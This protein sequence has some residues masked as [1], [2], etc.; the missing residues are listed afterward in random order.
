MREDNI[1][2]VIILRCG[3]VT[4]AFNSDQRL[5]Q[6][7]FTRIGGDRLRVNAP[8]DASISP[9]GFYFMYTVNK[10]NLPSL[11]IKVYITDI[12]ESDAERTWIG[13]FSQR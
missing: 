3:S 2:H 4:H 12:P 8:K 1:E 5:I 9:P 13:L 11:G 10:Q 6:L 7:G